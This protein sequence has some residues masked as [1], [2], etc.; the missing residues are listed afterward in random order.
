MRDR[1]PWETAQKIL[2]ATNAPRGMGW[3]RTL[4]KLADADPEAAKHIDA[5]RNS[6]VQQERVGEK[7][8]RFYRLSSGDMEEL[9]AKLLSSE[10]TSGPFSNKYPS[11]LTDGELKELG[12]HPHTLVAVEKTEDGIAA[13]YCAV[14]TIL[15]REA[16]SISGLGS[17]AADLLAGYDKVFGYKQRRMQAFDVVWVPHSGNYVDVR[18][19]YPDGVNIATGEIAQNEVRSALHNTIGQDYLTNEVNL[20]PLITPIYKASEGTVIEIAFETGSASRK[21]ETM[22]RKNLCLRKEPYHKGGSDAIFG[23]I[24]PYL[25]SV[26]WVRSHSRGVVSR[27]EVTFYGSARTASVGIQIDVV[28]RKCLDDS[29]Y[30]FVRS[31]I[32]HYLSELAKK[33]SQQNAAA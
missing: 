6:L 32:A 26:Q 29:D 23:D 2:S 5:L 7:L 11:L 28:I 25:L 13:V 12:S 22:R 1:V 15:I 16:V 17:A 4:Q 31:R 18:V 20:F 24:E 19:D 33:N 30:E 3:E 8:S 14:R 10:I 21:H 9:R 27:P